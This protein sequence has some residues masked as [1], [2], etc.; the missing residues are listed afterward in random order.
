VFIGPSGI[1]RSILV[2]ASSACISSAL[3]AQYEQP[4]APAAYALVGVTMIHADGHRNDGL[5]VVVRGSLIEAIGPGIAAPPDAQVLEGDSLWVYPALVDAQ[6]GE[7]FEFPKTEVDR[8]QVRSWA[9]PR[10]LQGFTPHRRIVD[11]LTATGASTKHYRLKGIVAAGVH[12]RDGLM[13]GRGTLL[14]Y[15]KSAA[16]PAELVL[17]P[18]LGPVMSFRGGQGVYPSTLF[19]VI[20]FHRQ[21][22]ED[23]RRLGTLLASYQRDPSGMTAP[24]WDPDY[25]VL[26]EV[27][28]GTAPVFFAADSTEDIRR[29]LGLATEFGFQP[30]IVGGA[31]AWRIADRLKA[32]NVPVLVSVNFPEPSRWKPEKQDVQEDE[33]K[34]EAAKPAEFEQAPKPL[35][36]AALREKEYF[37]GLWSNAGKLSAAGVRF[38]LTSGGG[39]GDLLKGAR[40][41]IEFGLPEVDA[42]RAVTATPAEL[43]GAPQL[44]RIEPG[45]A[46]TFVVTDGPLFAE[47]TRI[48]YTF[49]EGD[50]EKGAAKTSGGGPVEAPVVVLTGEWDVQVTSDQGSISATMTLKQDGASFSGSLMSEFGRMTVRD[51]TV[52]GSSISFTGIMD[53]GGQSL[54]MTF[55]GTAREN[56]VS[57]TGNGPFGALSWKAT[58]KSGP[59]EEV[60]Q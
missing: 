53:M 2:L 57:G 4:P 55:N 54:E 52:S 19:G 10:E 26:R 56:D 50:V 5:T 30:V 59:G 21:N 43:L 47:A 1:H 7:D 45:M 32:S 28:S 11:Y 37:E 23:A 14:L 29:A 33:K 48:L 6:G 18:A 8:S 9:P 46:A 15:R 36:A 58:R 27:T 41:A 42:L 60:V 22:F 38:A 3:R 25:A 51:G 44:V 31:G 13:P 49:V 35:D 34:E 12:P 17:A 24:G 16:T 20:A 39:K 40:K